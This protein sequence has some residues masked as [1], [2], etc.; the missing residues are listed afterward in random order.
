MRFFT[1]DRDVAERFITTVVDLSRGCY[2][3]K[4][5]AAYHDRRR[6]LYIKST[7]HS[8]PTLVG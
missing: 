7:H 6:G 5:L 3:V 2:E 1:F 8:A 4:A